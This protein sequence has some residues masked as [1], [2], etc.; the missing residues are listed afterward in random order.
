M[1]LVRLSDAGEEGQGWLTSQ[2]RKHAA[3]KQKKA[4]DRSSRTLRYVTWAYSVE[5]RCSGMP[6]TLHGLR[7]G[8]S[9][10][11]YRGSWPKWL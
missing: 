5:K 1:H 2:S 11:A 9:T 7:F 10:L 6:I 8:V 3:T 4:M